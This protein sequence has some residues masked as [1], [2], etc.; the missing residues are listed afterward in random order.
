MGNSLQEIK[1]LNVLS[2]EA[3]KYKML[4]SVF[5]K[6]QVQYIK[7]YYLVNY[8]Y[9]FREWLRKDRTYDMDDMNVVY[10]K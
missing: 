4:Q 7:Q 5:K 3:N 1:I 10:M 9:Y 8:W 2:F 6:L